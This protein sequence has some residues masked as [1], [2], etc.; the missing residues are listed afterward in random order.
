ML[1]EL[2]SF[3]DVNLFG[4]ISV[5]AGV[6]FFLSFTLTL[7][8][9]PRYLAWA[10]SKK[11]NQPISKY[12]PA[13]EGKRH[14]PTMGGAVFL[15]ATLIA[16]LLTVDLSNPYILAGL[17]ALLGF[18]LIGLK[19]DIGKVLAGDNLKGLTPRGKMGLQ[20]IIAALSTGILLYA[21]F[22]TEFYVPFFKTPLFDMGYG[23][24][25]FWVFVFLATTNAVNLTDGLDGLATVPSIIALASLG[26]IVYVTGHAIFSQYLLVP[27][28][29][30]VGEV[31][32]LAVALAGGLMGFLWYN[33]YPAEIFMGDTGSLAIG[34][35][36]AYLAIL[37]KS[38]IL[39]ILIGL[40]FVIETVSVILQVG[41]FKLRGKR[42]FLMAPIHHHFELKK[43]AENK[44]IVRFWMIAFLANMLALIS[45]K[46]R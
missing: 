23:A 14:T 34:G 43:W 46:F 29:K 10:I 44:I 35:F 12:V 41:S 30:G 9:M 40:I 4:Y 16:A 13:H 7:F 2:S 22:P 38:E 15:A 28:V 11:A 39:L 45:F 19:D 26:L 24:I 3:L 8:I 25:V 18:G 5:R 1:Y 17:L 37:G 32:I 27:N 31:T 21:G 20:I 33:C 42:V 6:A 36:L